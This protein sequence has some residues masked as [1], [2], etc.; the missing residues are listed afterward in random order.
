MTLPEI[1]G[2]RDAVGSSV[3]LWLYLS[4]YTDLANQRWQTVL[5]GGVVTDEQIA[6]HL[7][8]SAGQIRRWRRRL[9]NLGYIKTELV[10]PRHR[11]FWLSNTAVEETPADEVGT[12]RVN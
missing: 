5:S 10:S 4:N 3:W 8:V 12:V 7:D 1:L 6:F 9:E 2:N 11:R